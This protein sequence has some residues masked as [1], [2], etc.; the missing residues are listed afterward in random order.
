M[1]FAHSAIFVSGS[2][3]VKSSLR[4]SIVSVIKITIKM[5]TSQRNGSLYTKTIVGRLKQGYL[6]AGSYRSVVQISFAV[7][8]RP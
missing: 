2:E 4:Y 1:L 7:V 5:L 3:R 8:L 6:Y